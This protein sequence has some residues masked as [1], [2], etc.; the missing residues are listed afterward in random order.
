[1]LKELGVALLLS[2]NEQHNMN[3]K[4]K[5]AD[6]ALK[7]E[8]NHSWLLHGHHIHHHHDD[9]SNTTNTS[10]STNTSIANQWASKVKD[11]RIV[12]VSRALGGKDRHS[13][14]CTVRGLRDR[15]VR[16]SVPTAIQLYDLQDRLGLNQP[17]KVVDWLLNAAKHEINQLPPLQIPPGSTL[18]SCQYNDNSNNNNNNNEDSSNNSQPNEEDHH[19]HHELS[20]TPPSNHHHPSFLGLLNTMPLGLNSNSSQW[21]ANDNNAS[22]SS[23]GNNNNN[24]NNYHDHHLLQLQ[25]SSS[26]YFPSSSSM[27]MMQMSQYQMLMMSMMSSHSTSSSSSQIITP[28]LLNYPMNVMTHQTV[29]PFN[30][31]MMAPTKLLHSPKSSD[32]QSHSKHQD[33]PSK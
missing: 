24:S 29:K 7:G 21:E 10:T 11:P 5:E 26:S 6:F 1:M 2:N 19:H 12:R 31:S 8:E 27:D 20:T 16:L 18:S 23:S 28:S 4:S 9:K 3:T 22:S 14:V 17:S 15:R 30:F 25:G 33:F 13:K 32:S